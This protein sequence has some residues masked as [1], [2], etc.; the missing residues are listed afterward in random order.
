VA[1]DVPLHP[2]AM[3]PCPGLVE[4]HA[5]LDH[6]V[7]GLAERREVPEVTLALVAVQV[8]DGEHPA[9]P[10]VR[11]RAPLVAGVQVRMPAP[12]AAVAV[13]PLHSLSDPAPGGRVGA[14]VLVPQ[15][16]TISKAAS[17]ASA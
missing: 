15:K 1:I 4:A 6:E 2:G 9:L 5:A 16:G 10:I 12:L 8:V 14:A 7:A 13:Q 17:T 3:R 11:V